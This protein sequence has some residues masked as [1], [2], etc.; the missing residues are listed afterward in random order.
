VED[1]TLT[2]VWHHEVMRPVAVASF[3][4]VPKPED[5]RIAATVV[6]GSVGTREVLGAAGT[7]A[8]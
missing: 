7:A 1:R 6:A 2:F 8:A 5:Y 3:V 4:V